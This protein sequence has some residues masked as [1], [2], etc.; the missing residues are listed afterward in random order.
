M[1]VVLKIEGMM[2]PHCEAHVTKALMEVG[3]VEKVVASHKDG[4]A[5]ITTS[6]GADLGALKM[7]VE[8]AGY[9]VIG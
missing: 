5:V 3:K 4:T 8:N 9:K 2:C 1:E 6:D 7:A